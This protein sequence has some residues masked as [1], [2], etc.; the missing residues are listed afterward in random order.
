MRRLVGK[1]LIGGLAALLACAPLT[2][3]SKK[4]TEDQRIELLRGL[5]AEYATIKTL[6]P[7]SK[8]TLEFHAD[9]TWDQAVW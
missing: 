7:I 6:L 2:A 4:L 1:S 3:D 9:G 5:M 8:K